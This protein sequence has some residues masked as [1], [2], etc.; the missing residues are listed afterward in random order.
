MPPTRVARWPAR[1]VPSTALGLL[2]ALPAAVLHSQEQGEPTPDR[3]RRIYPCAD[4]LARDLPEPSNPAEEAQARY[5]AQSDWTLAR[6]YAPILRFAPGERYYPTIPFFPAFYS[7]SYVVARRGTADPTGVGGDTDPRRYAGRRGT[8]AES[9]P[10]Y[11]FLRDQYARLVDPLR[12]PHEQQL[13]QPA[14]VYRVCDLAAPGGRWADSADWAGPADAIWRYLRSDEQSWDRFGLDT[15]TTGLSDTTAPRLIRDVTQFRVIQ[16]FFY[17]VGDWGLAGHEHD[18]EFTFVFVPRDTLIARKF[19]IVVGAGHD[20]P[21]PNNVLVYIGPPADT[22]K[23]FNQNILVELGGHSS[24]PDMP[25]FGQFSSG[26]DVNWHIDDV[27]G[28]RDE[29]ATGGISFSGRYEGTMTYPR[30]QEDALSLFPAEEALD[31]ATKKMLRGLVRVAPDAL[32]TQVLAATERQKDEPKTGR[33]SL[34]DSVLAAYQEVNRQQQELVLGVLSTEVTQAR[35]QADTFTQRVAN[36]RRAELIAAI[37][38]VLG[39]SNVAD[40][41]QRAKNLVTWIDSTG[42]FLT[43][44]A[45]RTGVA[46]LLP[47]GRTLA[48]EVRDVVD[49]RIEPRYRLIPAEY[50]QQLTAAAV[51]RDSARVGRYLRYITRDLFPVACDGLDCRAPNPRGD[52]YLTAF[53]QIVC[54]Q[55]RS[56]APGDTVRW[57][58]SLACAYETLSPAARDTVLEQMALWDGDLWGGAGTLAAYRHKI[59]QRPTY[60]DP[61]SL[62]RSELFRPTALQTRNSRHAAL[63]LFT[64]SATYTDHA[65]LPALGFIIPAFRSVDMPIR[66][67]GYLEVQAGPYIPL[68]GEGTVVRPAVALL[69][70]RRFT[71]FWGWYVKPLYVFGR[72]RAQEPRAGSDFTVSAGASFWVPSLLGA[73]FFRWLHFRP[74]FRMDT[75]GFHPD[76]NRIKWDLQLE[77]RR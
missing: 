74:G 44:D 1:L 62:F 53:R 48:D 55:D 52:R 20:P 26:L 68:S 37:R 46:Q 36:D 35:I 50:L 73:R 16:Y 47:H 21:A 34:A 33:L 75:E 67:P 45:L 56:V 27:W 66:I 31:T 14:V 10:S 64:L 2:L 54:G 76:L 9:L 29:Q 18:I 39:T 22:R 23:H 70:D 7:D 61:G 65:M 41:I 51:A 43:L 69:Y 17:Y 25:P 19:R 59:W 13:A 30:D 32:A 42:R 4:T 77:Y 63:K 24:A 5:R 15:V 6:K 12:S 38:T 72:K 40:S 60:I 58:R 71:Y 28:T 11:A 3:D 49:K 8:V 57:P